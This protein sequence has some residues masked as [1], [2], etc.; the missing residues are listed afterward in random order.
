M[1]LLA[2]TVDNRSRPAV[3][4][5]A[6]GGLAS[7]GGLFIDAGRP[8]IAVALGGAGI[9][10]VT[11]GFYGVA[12]HHLG[13][14]A[15]VGTPSLQGLVLIET[16]AVFLLFADV[17]PG[18]RLLSGTLAIPLAVVLGVITALLASVEGY[19]IAA[20]TP[21]VIVAVGTYAVHRYVNVKLGLAAEEAET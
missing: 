2:F 10:Y 4:L 19:G 1:G 3:S 6:V 13:A 18:H 7:T 12:I 8:G 11:A 16:A 15:L 17:P 14:L 20:I 9:A 21:V 5:L